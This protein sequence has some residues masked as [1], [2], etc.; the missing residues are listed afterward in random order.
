MG[1]V[2]L[3]THKVARSSQWDRGGQGPGRTEFELCKQEM[4][5]RRMVVL[6]HGNANVLTAAGKWWRWD[7]Y[8]VCVTTT[9]KEQGFIVH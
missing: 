1:T 3:H 9:Y 8:A 7:F 5:R 2:R 6:P 4:F